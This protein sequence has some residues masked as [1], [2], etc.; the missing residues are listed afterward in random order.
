MKKA[1]D[2][3]TS[4]AEKKADALEGIKLVLLNALAGIAKALYRIDNRSAAAV[5]DFIREL[6]HRHAPEVEKTIYRDA[7]E[8]V[9]P[10]NQYDDYD[11][12]DE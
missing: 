4:E 3:Q 10:E 6:I 12:Y 8:P 2:R 9:I 11:Y 1:G 7:G 5:A